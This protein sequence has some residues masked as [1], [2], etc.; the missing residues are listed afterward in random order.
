M[1]CLNIS[2]KQQILILW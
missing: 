2:L 1:T